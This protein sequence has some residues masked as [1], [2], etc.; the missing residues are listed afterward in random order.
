MSIAWLE[1]SRSEGTTC[2]CFPCRRR[3]PG[4]SY[5]HVP[6]APGKHVSTLGRMFIL[7]FRLNGLVLDDLDILHLH[8]DDWFYL[9]RSIPTIRTFHGSALDEAR[10]ASGWPRRASQASFDLRQ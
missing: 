3:P 9:R 5:D 4:A 2:A 1:S 6:V 10:Y 8:G 7:P